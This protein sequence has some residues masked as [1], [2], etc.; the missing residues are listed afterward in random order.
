MEYA[1]QAETFAIRKCLMNVDNELGNGFLEKVYQE[2]LA[3]EFKENGIDYE[4]E[5][6]LPV[7][8]KGVKLEQ[9]YI[10]DFVCFGKVIVEVKAVTKLTDVHRAQLMNYLKVTNLEVGLLVNFCGEELEIERW[11]NKYL[12]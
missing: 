12:K 1:A 5:V 8:Y 2:A 3:I 10:A 4:R 9:E 7:F 6:R 11:F